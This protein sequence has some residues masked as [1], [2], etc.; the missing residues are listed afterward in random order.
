MKLKA[1]HLLFLAILI[2]Q[3]YHTFAQSDIYDTIRVDGR[4][5]EYVI[6]F[7]PSCDS[8][9]KVPILL[10]LYGGGSSFE[11]MMKF[12][13]LN[14]LADKNYFAV[15][16]PKT[17][18][19]SWSIPGF[20]PRVKDYDS[21]IDDVHFISVLLDSIIQIYNVDST[22]IFAA[23]FS[24]GGEFALYLADKLSSRITAIASVCASLPKTVLKGFSFKHPVSVLLINGTADPI[25]KYEGGF[26]K[27]LRK[28]KCVA[29]LD[30]ASTD[31]LISKIITMDSCGTKP[32]AADMPNKNKKD[33][34]TAVKYKY[35]CSNSMVTFIMVING[36]HTWPGGKQYLPKFMVGKVCKDFK[37]QN[38]IFDFFLLVIRK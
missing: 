32:Q 24:R 30:I 18:N 31:D 1:R 11:N 8:I 2:F 26:G 36:G 21:T 3:G 34:C 12:Y 28:R 7:P 37:A 29:G 25:I 9:K 33:G 10:A 6:H 35:W 38:E 20:P 14:G 5:R 19:G 16:Y 27:Y 4:L 22:K 13:R 23:G 15:I 17:I